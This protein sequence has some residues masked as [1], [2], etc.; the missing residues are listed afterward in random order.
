MQCGQAAEFGEERNRGV[1]VEL[2]KS[3]VDRLGERLRGGSHT[4]EDLRLLEV[5]KQSFGPAY[6]QVLRK[7]QRHALAVKGRPEK[8]TLSIESKLRRDEKMRLS[9]MQ[10]IAGGRIVVDNILEQN[11][12]VDLLRQ[13]FLEGKV[14]DRRE[15]PSHGYRAVHLI[16]RVE[17]KLVEIQIRT[18]LQ[19]LW[20]EFSEKASDIVGLDIKYG[21][22]PEDWRKS[23][24]VMSDVI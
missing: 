17:E 2:S 7:L 19:Q 23:L 4:E 20:A 15:K 24:Q 13:D 11:R 22:G 9:R 14:M 6:E 12:V 3:Q 10:D 1:R 8:S 18:A 5:Y 16:V 21:G